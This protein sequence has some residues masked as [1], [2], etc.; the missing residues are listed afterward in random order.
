GLLCLVAMSMFM[1]PVGAR[2][3]H[4]LPVPTLKKCFACVL[5]VVAIKMLYGAIQAL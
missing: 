1:A 3:A 4:S 5:I 2:L